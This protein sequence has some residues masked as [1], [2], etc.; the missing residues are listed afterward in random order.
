MNAIDFFNFL[1]EK[2]YQR[3]KKIKPLNNLSNRIIQNQE[4][5]YHLITHHN[6]CTNA[7]YP[8]LLS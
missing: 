4:N 6:V 1:K 7:Q 8:I 5:N 2:K 3:E